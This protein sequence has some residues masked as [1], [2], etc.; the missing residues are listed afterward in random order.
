MARTSLIVYA[1]AFLLLLVAGGVLVVGARGFLD[2]FTLL[3]AS[4]ACSVAAILAA[5]ASV[6][7]P[8]R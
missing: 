4:I 6:L 7:I 5:A 1:V 8:R 3:W 2:S